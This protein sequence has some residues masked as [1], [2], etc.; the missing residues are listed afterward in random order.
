L[1]ARAQTCSIPAPVATHTPTSQ[2]RQTKED[3][4]DPLRSISTRRTAQRE[5]ADPRQVTNAAG[6]Y[7]FTVDHQAR[8]HRFLTLGTDGGTYYT[9]ARELIRDNADVVFRAAA[10]DPVGLVRQIV[11]VSTA[12]RAPR[13]NP[14]L[15][16]LAIA[17]SAEDVDG[18][19]A[20]LAALPEVARI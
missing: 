2:P 9:D 5:P 13:K 10:S 19:R 17:A 16:A 7:T 11:E 18:R 8:L 4:V 6:G 20:A 14:A 1:V 12:G 3:T 15:F